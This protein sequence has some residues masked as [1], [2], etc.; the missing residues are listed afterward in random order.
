MTEFDPKKTVSQYS[1]DLNK[2]F[3]ARKRRRGAKRIVPAR[4]LDEGSGLTVV[5]HTETGAF[6]FKENDKLVATLP[7]KKCSGSAPIII[8]RPFDHPSQRMEFLHRLVHLV[9]TEFSA[10]L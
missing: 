8:Q 10:E 5:C 4:V 3:E 9:Q 7:C 6:V 1:A 2:V